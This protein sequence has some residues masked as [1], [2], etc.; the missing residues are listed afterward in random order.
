MQ[1]Q[2]KAQ[3][4]LVSVTGV[5]T[6][7]KS[8]LH[9]SHRC[10]ACKPGVVLNRC[11]LKLPCFLQGDAATPPLTGQIWFC[12]IFFLLLLRSGQSLRSRSPVWGSGRASAP[13]QGC[14]K[15]LCERDGV[16]QHSERGAANLSLLSQS[17]SWPS[18]LFL[19]LW[20]PLY[21][22]SSINKSLFD[23]S[24]CIQ[25]HRRKHN[26]STW[27]EW[28]RWEVVPLVKR[29]PLWRWESAPLEGWRSDFIY[30]HVIIKIGKSSAW[31]YS[32][33]R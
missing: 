4:W 11:H 5:L 18:T 22:G 33:E 6:R 30:H 17:L 3:H 7:C 9:R 2:P 13:Y 15:G 21:F 25:S 32:H 16:M 10:G 29:W 24:A 28:S 31:F 1:K 12:Q 19:W 27:W 14:Y 20:F 8:Q 26:H 23:A